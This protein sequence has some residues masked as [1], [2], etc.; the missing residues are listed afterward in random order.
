MFCC[1]P[2]ISH[3]GFRRW[4]C[5]DLR[6]GRE[7]SFELVLQFKWKLK[8]GKGEHQLEL[9]SKKKKL[10]VCQDAENSQAAIQYILGLSSTEQSLL[11]RQHAYKCTLNFIQLIKKQVM[12]TYRVFVKGLSFELLLPNFKLQKLFLM[13]CVR[14]AF[15]LRLEELLFYYYFFIGSQTEAR[16]DA[17]I[18]SCEHFELHTLLS[19][20]LCG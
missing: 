10:C 18:H 5:Q 13:E 8:Q 11:L 9:D 12:H 15:K 6:K 20:I 1:W 3:Q 7:N 4:H 16:E 19:F 2:E 17:R 14:F